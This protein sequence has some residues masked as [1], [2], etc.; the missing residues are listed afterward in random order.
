MQKNIGKMTIS[1]VIIMQIEELEKE[2][3]NNPLKFYSNYVKYCNSIEEL[4]NVVD[5][6]DKITKQIDCSQ[7]DVR[8]PY[9]LTILKI[10]ENFNENW[11]KVIYWS[12]KLNP[13]LL[14]K[15]NYPD[16]YHL[17]DKEQWYLLTS[18]ALLNLNYYDEAIELSKKALDD[19]TY[20]TEFNGTVQ[21]CHDVALIF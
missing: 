2:Y 1:K 11:E 8:C 5:V 12:R 6:L 7:G 10:M 15:D 20:F 9:T 19:L 18:N 16:G 14:S 4:I 3:K 13:D 17:S 21:N